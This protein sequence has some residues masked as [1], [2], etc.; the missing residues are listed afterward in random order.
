MWYICLCSV[1]T[2]SSPGP[3]ILTAAS[4]RPSSRWPARWPRHTSALSAEIMTTNT[5]FSFHTDSTGRTLVSTL[6]QRVNAHCAFVTWACVLWDIVDIKGHGKSMLTLR[7][8]AITNKH[9]PR[10]V[11]D[12]TH[13]TKVNVYGRQ[14]HYI[15]VNTHSIIWVVCARC[16]GLTAMLSSRRFVHILRLA[17]RHI[18]ISPYNYCCIWRTMLATSSSFTWILDSSFNNA[19]S[20]W[21]F[22]LRKVFKFRIFE[23][24]QTW[25][26][27]S[28]RDKVKFYWS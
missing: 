19:K 20:L 3:V 5:V 10:C 18:E 12:G 23:S 16:G 27:A 24:V 25:Q 4:V 13:Y 7:R 26:I 17:E 1:H 28:A 9:I 8:T 14:A 22:A 6:E 15:N 2:H 11:N 21:V